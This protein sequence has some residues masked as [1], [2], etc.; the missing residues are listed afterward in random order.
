[1]I[2]TKMRPDKD[3]FSKNSEKVL[4]TAKDGSYMSQSYLNGKQTYHKAKK[5]C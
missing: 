4:W 5:K 2:K 3:A 1:M